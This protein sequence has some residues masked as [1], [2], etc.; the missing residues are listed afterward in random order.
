MKKVVVATRTSSR[1]PKDGV[2]IAEKA[3][4]RAMARNDIAGNIL[5]S[6]PFTILS[7]TP[8]SMIQNVL[9]DLN[10]EMENAEIQIGVFKAEELAREALAEANYKI[11]LE[12]QK[13]RDKP[14]NDDPIEEL[15]MEVIDNSVRY[16]ISNP[17]GT[18]LTMVVEN[19]DSGIVVTKNPK[20]GGLGDIT[21]TSKQ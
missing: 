15:T 8:D 12:K 3:A 5:P 10:I 16:D 17:M 9:G 19:A 2:P 1:I 6:N 13:E 4:S 7:D 14:V 18:D 20:G 21:K 11:F